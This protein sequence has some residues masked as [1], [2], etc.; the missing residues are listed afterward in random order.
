VGLIGKALLCIR[1][2][3]FDDDI[4]FLLLCLKLFY[5]LTSG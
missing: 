3:C 4:N 5:F 2:L 1:L